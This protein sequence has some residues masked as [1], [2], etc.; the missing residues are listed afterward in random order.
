MRV[1]LLCSV[2][3]LIVPC[4]AR[5]ESTNAIE[6]RIKQQIQRNTNGRVVPDSVANTPV[7]GVYEVRSGLDIIYVD[8][9]GQ[10]AFVE[11][12]LLDL[13]ANRDLTQDRLDAAARIDFKALPFDLALKT[14]RGSGTRQLAIFE[15]PTCPYCRALHTLLDQLD[16]VTIY[17][18]PFP[19]LSA[20]SDGKARAAL[21]A[22]DRERAWRELMASGHAPNARPCATQVDKV[23]ALGNRLDVR[24]TPT[25]FFSD[26]RRSQGAVPPDQFMNMLK[27]TPP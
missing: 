11:G 14:V 15:D 12:H 20:E 3:W 26:G 24:G 17:T 7:P 9:E 19:V 22:T 16:D 13:K 1:A 18:F 4:S 10:F 27:Q 5:C 23:I 21:C 25:V 2:L 8:R 6:A